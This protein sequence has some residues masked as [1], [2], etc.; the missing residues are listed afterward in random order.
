MGEWEILVM[1]I[2]CN[3]LFSG[4]AIV[5][6]YGS[7]CAYVLHVYSGSVSSGASICEQYVEETGL[8][9]VTHI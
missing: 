6:R 8:K 1:Y 5:C 2:P 9:R 4:N 3:C 7:L